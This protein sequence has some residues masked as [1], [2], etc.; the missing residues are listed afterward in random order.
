MVDDR[1]IF[2]FMLINTKPSKNNDNPNEDYSENYKL[3]TILNNKT[4]TV[5]KKQIKFKKKTF[6]MK[7]EL[8]TTN[9]RTL[10]INTE[11][12]IIN[13]LPCD[14]IVRFSDKQIIIKKCTQYYIDNNTKN[15]LFVTFTLKA[16]EGVF[17]SKGINI[18]N[19]GC[20]NENNYI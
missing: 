9:L 12:S 11:Y 18:I 4:D 1:T 5:Y 13:C 19:L 14:I 7:L 20:N 10:I 6:L 8:K 16:K 2:N 15:D 17:T 3:D